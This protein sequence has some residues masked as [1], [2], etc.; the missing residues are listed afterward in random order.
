M[1][2][3]VI[4]GIN[5]CLSFFLSRACCFPFYLSRRK[6]SPS[7]GFLQFFVPKVGA[8]SE[9]RVLSTSLFPICLDLCSFFGVEILRDGLTPLVVSLG[10]K[11]LP[12]PPFVC[13][14]FFAVCCFPPGTKTPPT[15]AGGS[16]LLPWLITGDIPSHYPPFFPPLR[17]VLSLFFFLSL[18]FNPPILSFR[19]PGKPLFL[20]PSFALPFLTS[21]NPFPSLGV[22]NGPLLV[23]NPPHFHDSPFAVYTLLYCPP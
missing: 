14:P 18:P 20:C 21:S 10:P 7:L 1:A 16:G 5:S 13:L 15:P 17:F 23:L 11:S 6:R 3:E 2:F 9:H 19:L 8:L 12:P 4:G 22:T